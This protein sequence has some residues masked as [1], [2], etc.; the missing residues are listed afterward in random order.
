MTNGKKTIKELTDIISELL[1]EAQTL[2]GDQTAEIDN[3]KEMNT[4]LRNNI[5]SLEDQLR[6]LAERNGN[7]EKTLIEATY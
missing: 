2:S 7:L 6:E 4:Q 3:L 1:F 5:Y